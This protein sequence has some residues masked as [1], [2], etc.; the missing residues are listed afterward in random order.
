[1]ICKYTEKE[2]YSLQCTIS[3]YDLFMDWQL[4]FGDLTEKKKPGMGRIYNDSFDHLTL[5]PIPN[6]MLSMD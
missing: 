5:S 3:N 1:M 6:I 2:I 4:P